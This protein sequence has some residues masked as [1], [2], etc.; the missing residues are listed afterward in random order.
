[1]LGNGRPFV[2]EMVDSKKAISTKEEL[3]KE[4]EVKI[5]E[6]K[7][8]WLVFRKPDF[9]KFLIKVNVNSLI[10]SNEK[11]FEILKQYEESK[12]KVYVSLVSS[13]KHLTD[14]DISKL[15]NLD[16]LV[17]RNDDFIYNSINFKDQTKNSL[18]SF[19]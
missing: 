8:V 4:M 13:N 1:M 5:N 11:C 2:L 10:F 14:E 16:E 18:K 12:L 17:V 9:L 15:N 6:S 19:A 7:D 3:L